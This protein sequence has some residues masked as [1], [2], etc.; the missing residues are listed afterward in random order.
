[1]KIPTDGDLLTATVHVLRSYPYGNAEPGPAKDM[2]DRLDAL[3]L[4]HQA[5]AEPLV[6]NTSAYM[7]GYHAGRTHAGD[8]TWNDAIEAAAK[9]CDGVNNYDNPMT[10]NDC[11]DGIRALSRPSQAQQSIKPVSGMVE[12]CQI[13]YVPIEVDPHAEAGGRHPN[14]T[15]PSDA[16]CEAVLDTMG[17]DK[18]QG[19]CSYWKWGF[20]AGWLAAI[21]RAPQPVSGAVDEREALLSTLKTALER[22]SDALNATYIAKPEDRIQHLSDVLVQAKFAMEQARAAL[23][24]AQQAPAVSD[25]LPDMVSKALR[26]AFSLGQTYWQQADSAYTSHHKEAADTQRVFN[27]LIDATCTAIAADREGK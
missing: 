21:S 5:Q 8:Q 12:E 4:A 20:H 15:T 26:R 23:S 18:D 7:S 24:R 14:D 13:V 16:R 11:A 17:D 1:M 6:E 19:L 22:A 3:L 25:D 2:A 9:V 10:A 27:R